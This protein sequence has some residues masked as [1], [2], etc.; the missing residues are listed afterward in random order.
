MFPFP[1]V[2]IVTHG[3]RRGRGVED[4]HSSGVTNVL[5]LARVHRALSRGD[6]GE[7]D[8]P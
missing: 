8:L 7:L 5:A 6:V 2:A 3:A 4:G 1:Y